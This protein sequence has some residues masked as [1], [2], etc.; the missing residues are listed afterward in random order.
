MLKVVN[1]KPGDARRIGNLQTIS[2]EIARVCPNVNVSYYDVPP[3]FE[4][5]AEAAKFYRDTDILMMPHGAALTN[6]IFM[7]EG[8]TVF[9]WSCDKTSYDYPILANALGLNYMSAEMQTMPHKRAARNTM[10][11]AVLEETFRLLREVLGA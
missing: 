10:S 2:S 6:M 1:R 9:E 7:R 11:K 8:T 5:L 4:S 3:M